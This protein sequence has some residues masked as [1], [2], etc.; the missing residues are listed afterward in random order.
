MEPSSMTSLIPLWLVEL[1]AEGEEP[2]T[3]V[4][5]GPLKDIWWSK[6][7]SQSKASSRGGAAEMSCRPWEKGEAALPGPMLARDWGE[8]V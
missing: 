4:S 2:S 3:A 1:M 7:G 8:S 5:L 6:P